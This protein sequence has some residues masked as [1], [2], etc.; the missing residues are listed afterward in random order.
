MANAWH[1]DT[2]DALAGFAFA[3]NRGE[4]LDSDEALSE[5][6]DTYFIEAPHF[7]AERVSSRAIAFGASRGRFQTGLYVGGREAAFPSLSA[8]CEFVRRCYGSGGGSDEGPGALG[9]L[10]PPPDQPQLPPELPNRG[11][12]PRESAQ[13]DPVEVLQTA[14]SSFEERIKSQNSRVTSGEQSSF[15][16]KIAPT[17]IDG[18]SSSMRLARAAFRLILETIQHS[19]A[20]SPAERLVADEGGRKLY[21]CISRMGL[22]I[23]IRELIERDINAK[24]VALAVM[25]Q[26]QAAHLYMALTDYF[27]APSELAAVM[28][29][30]LRLQGDGAE[31]RLYES[32]RW[33]SPYRGLVPR[34]F[35]MMMGPVGRSFDP[36]ADLSEIPIP[37]GFL[38]QQYTSSGKAPTI[39]NLIAFACNSPTLIDPNNRGEVCETL[40]FSACY[41]TMLSSH[42]NPIANVP[43]WDHREMTIGEVELMGVRRMVTS[44]MAWL[45]SSFPTCAFT[46][47]LE[48]IIAD[49]ASL[50][51]LSKSGPFV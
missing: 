29:L 49:T 34:D 18:Y 1:I 26:S 36:F 10:E 5:S 48:K 8:V 39:R 27:K 9:P 23:Y 47:E 45:S 15:L 35:S 14:F 7:V 22:W 30:E 20:G 32:V 19:V 37:I 11:E 41:L 6:A 13:V 38:P 28:F 3:S 21:A 17:G 24:K 12:F 4:D 50:R 51:R 42:D 43:Y 44:A 16:G 46:G 33:L 40:L 31:H 2:M 25:E